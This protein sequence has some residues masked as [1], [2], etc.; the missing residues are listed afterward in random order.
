MSEQIKEIEFEV[1]PKKQGIDTHGRKLLMVG[2]ILH[3][4]FTVSGKIV[5]FGETKS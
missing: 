3:T 1:V 5:F 2:L 4:C